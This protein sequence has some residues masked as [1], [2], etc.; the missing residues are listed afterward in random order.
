MRGLEYRQLVTEQEAVD[1]DFGVVITMAAGG[2][3]GI[4]EKAIRD[5]KMTGLR[6]HCLRIKPSW[7]CSSH[8]G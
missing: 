4:A 1:S 2:S 5:N 7:K 6:G 3:G 8:Q